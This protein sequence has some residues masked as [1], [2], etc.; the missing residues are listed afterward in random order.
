ML[1]GWYMFQVDSPVCS[2]DVWVGKYNKKDAI[3]LWDKY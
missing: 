1:G 3:K 2:K